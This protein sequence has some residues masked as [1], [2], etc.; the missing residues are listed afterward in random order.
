MGDTYEALAVCGGYV[1]D[2]SCK[3]KTAMRE[4]K[5]LRE[6]W[7]YGKQK[8][9]KKQYVTRKQR[10]W[11]YRNDVRVPVYSRYSE[12]MTQI[13]RQNARLKTSRRKTWCSIALP[14]YAYPSR[15][16]VIPQGT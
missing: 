5:T 12:Q 9:K 13:A 6:N 11:R 4:D 2:K 7:G 10:V 15:E 16:G 3:S 8:Y 14:S 1:P